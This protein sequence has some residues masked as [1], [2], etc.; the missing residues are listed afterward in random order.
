MLL[1]AAT[2]PQK[3]LRSLVILIC[4]IIK[5]GAWPTHLWYIKLIERIKIKKSLMLIITWQKILPIYVLSILSDKTLIV[6]SLRVF[7]ILSSMRWLK[8]NISIKRTIALS[9]LNNNGWII[10]CILR[11][12]RTI[13][14]FLSAYLLTLWRSLIE[15][16]KIT[17]KTK[18]TPKKFWIYTSTVRNLGGVPPLTIFW[19]KIIV[20]KICLS[21]SFTEEVCIILVFSACIF[22][23][24]YLWIAINEINQ[25]PI[26]TQNIIKRKEENKIIFMFLISSIIV[27][28]TMLGL[29]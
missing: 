23:Y 11:S 28:L 18:I 8:K 1:I 12:I 25:P 16:K 10:I 9:S 15:I 24:F 27:P 21:G 6:I 4:I 3:R 20:L 7:C 17:L 29:T 14:I 19:V 5:L 22:I 26:K 13:L 2:A